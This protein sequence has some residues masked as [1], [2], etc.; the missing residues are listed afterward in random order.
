MPSLWFVVEE[1]G[2]TAPDG[3]AVAN[4]RLSGGWSW[5]LITLGVVIIAV[6]GLLL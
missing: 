1:V 5:L 2:L 6:G 3:A 4:I